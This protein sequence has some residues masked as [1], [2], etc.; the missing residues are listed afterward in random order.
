MATKMH[1]IASALLRHRC[2]TMISVSE[3]S[4]REFAKPSHVPTRGFLDFLLV[5]T[6]TQQRISALCFPS[7]SIYKMHIVQLRRSPGQP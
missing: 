5:C 4:I 3:A 1:L 6:A 2:W 7:S